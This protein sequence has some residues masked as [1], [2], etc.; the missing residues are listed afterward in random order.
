MNCGLVVTSASG[1]TACLLV[2][3]LGLA[4]CGS[5]SAPEVPGHG[6][7]P[8]AEHAADVAEWRKGRDGRL[9]SEDG[10]L[11]L[12][13][14]DWLAEGANP[15]G[16][17][18]DNRI[19]LP[20]GP[21]SWGVVY[22]EPGG[23]RFEAA[24]GAAVTVDGWPA[25]SVRLVPD[26][27]GEP[28]VVRSGS[29]SFHVIHRESYALRVQDR[30]APTLVAFEGVENYPT[31][32]EWRIDAD[33][34]PA[35]PGTEIEV[36]DVLGQI[37]PY[38]VPGHVEFERDGKRHRLT[39]IELPDTDS[40]WLIFADRTS[41]RE[42]YPAGRFLYSEGMP[43]DGRLA[44]DFNKA[45]NPPCAFSDYATCPLPPQENRL[46]LAV[47]AGEK[48]FHAMAATH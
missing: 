46:D 19:R 33:F 6:G 44:V 35:P 37:T 8:A 13:G 39:A 43:A 20:G 31:R 30:Q 14:L 22:L 28:T 9:R 7:G 40:L 25:A 32:L 16:S 18:S 17:G 12:V 27:A 48:T 2:V 41:G 34:V 5:E 36:G 42:T 23:L 21:E 15:V 26:D 4:S 29:L 1:R 38:K 11:T 10:W 3:A 47:T 24:P 45:Y